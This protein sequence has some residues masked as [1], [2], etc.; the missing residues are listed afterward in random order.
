M[1]LARLEA[2]FC[3]ALVLVSARLKAAHFEVSSIRTPI[4]GRLGLHGNQPNA[5][6]MRG[7]LNA[8]KLT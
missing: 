8:R 4:Q 3:V 6:F 5:L 2:A 1:T 7:D